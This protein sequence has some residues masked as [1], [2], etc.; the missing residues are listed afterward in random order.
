MKKTLTSLLLCLALLLPV[1]TWATVNEVDPARNDYTASG[2]TQDFP[3]TFKVNRKG[4]IQVLVNGVVK[5]VDTDY[6]VSNLGASGGA[7]VHFLTAPAANT[8][9]AIVRDQAAEQ[10]SRYQTGEAFPATR[11][12][13][14][15]DKLAMQIQQDREML[16][17]SLKAPPA[18]NLDMALPSVASRG[19]NVLGF[20]T[21]GLP[22]AV[23][24]PT[25]GGGDVSLATTLATG[26]SV[27]RT[28]AERA[29]EVR[30][31]V[32]YGAVGNGT[33]NDTAAIQAAAA[34]ISTAGGGLLY[35]PPGT[36]QV[37]GTITL[38]DNTTV[39]GTA[40]TIRQTVGDAD[41]PEIDEAHI[42]SAPLFQTTSQDNVWLD[43]R[44]VTL[45]GKGN[46]KNDWTSFALHQDRGVQLI[47]CTRCGILGGNFKNFSAAA[48][49]LEGGNGITIAYPHIEGTHTY[50]VA[51]KNPTQNPPYGDNLQFG[52]AVLGTSAYAQLSN[53]KILA[54]EIQD[55]ATG[56]TWSQEGD[57][58]TSGTNRQ[59]IGANIHDIRGQHGLYIESGNVSV[60]APSIYN[61]PLLGL[62]F[63]THKG[64]LLENLEAT[65]VNI[66]STGDS[67]VAAL[68]PDE[69][70]AII[71]ASNASPIEI[72]STAHGMYT[73]ASV[74]TSAVGGNSAA[75]GTYTIT[76][77]D[78]DHYTLDGTTG[79]GSYA[80]LTFDARAVGDGGNVD[81][82]TEYVT[83][84]GHGLTGS[85]MVQLTTAGALPTGL[86]TGTT[87]YYVVV[88]A[89]TLY[90]STTKNGAAK[91]L[92]AGGT[93]TATLV[94]YSL[95]NSRLR[96]VRFTG[97]ALSTNY[98]VE[99]DTRISQGYADMVIA[100]TTKYGCYVEGKDNHDIE[101][102]VQVYRPGR[103]GC[104]IQ[105]ANSDGIRLY[106]TVRDPSQASAGTYSGI[107]VGNTSGRLDIY[108]PD[109]T[110]T[111]SSM[112]NGFVS[113][114]TLPT[115]GIYGR[116]VFTGATAY[117]VRAGGALT[118][119]PAHFTVTGSTANFFST[120]NAW[121]TQSA[122]RSVTRTYANFAG[123]GTTAD[124]TVA[125]LPAKTRLVA[126]YADVT[127]PFTGGGVTT[128]TMT[129][130]VSAGGNQL[131]VSFDVNSATIQRGLA[132][133]DLG[134]SINRANAIQ[135]AYLGS[136]TATTVIS[137]RL[138]VDGAHTTGD[139][140]A[141]SLTVSLVTERL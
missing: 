18:D 76:R 56:L 5:T 138:T 30:N 58:M 92:T 134:T 111:T 64:L 26:S 72:T 99:F 136:W 1:T 124:S 50:G 21:A 90:F 96:N 82:A 51:I 63:Q 108:N 80:A 75:N 53:V 141:G 110:D 38:T 13:G 43:L 112:L 8:T 16:R 59:V 109:V 20:T 84:T 119:F 14:D 137:C 81:L 35:F 49:V 29:A 104:L 139:L 77:V 25:A 125:T 123:G 79:S 93:G 70:T 10:Q 128:G 88:D 23:P 42:T 34:A 45:Y 66:R 7:T 15:L 61:T 46:Y 83:I 65:D 95:P 89:N 3:T 69:P 47:D 4:D 133:A 33:A 127:V 122:I 40:A 48:I 54:P 140:T 126:I 101:L 60:I 27:E 31:V 62:K 120:A 105:P 107:T 135:G 118:A 91:D 67:A 68:A 37:G 113:N 22:T 2:S 24:L 100:D 116:A 6:T 55:V 102:H 106:P 39:A 17:R 114:G 132:D 130:G 12:E 74:T 44:T 73:G 87:Y 98:G 41:D 85:G 71:T 19:G 32:D 57:V 97:L 94:P 52:I 117:G 121:P 36:Y 103:D 28:L 11:I 115:V 78:A 129:C 131:L 86:A 9:I